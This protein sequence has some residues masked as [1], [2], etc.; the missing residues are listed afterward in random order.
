MLD[1]RDV[2]RALVMVLASDLHP[3]WEIDPYGFGLSIRAGERGGTVM[4]DGVYEQVLAHPDDEPGL[5]TRFIDGLA[6]GMGTA[7][8]QSLGDVKADLFLAARPL[9]LYESLRNRPSGGQLPFVWPALPD[10]GIYWAV[11]CGCAVRYPTRRE[12]H[13]WGISAAE[14]TRIAWENTVADCRQRVEVKAFPDDRG[15]LI[16]S[17]G[18]FQSIGH[19]LYWRPALIDLL[20]TALPS[21]L[22][23]PMVLCAP[24]PHVLAVLAGPFNDYIAAIHQ[25]AIRQYDWLL[26]ESVYLLQRERVIGKVIGEH[27]GRSIA[28]AVEEWSTRSKEGP[29]MPYVPA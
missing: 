7:A 18:R 14:V 24:A 15:V 10:I 16:G 5:I 21:L 27:D 2:F 20:E 11:D 25:T 3:D 23:N 29:T 8:V 4:L 9:A 17:S 22:L 6:S 26:S 1:R 28:V 12:F 13:S 19:L